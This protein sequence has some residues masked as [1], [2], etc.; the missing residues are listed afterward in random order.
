[1]G[2]W[3]KKAAEPSPAQGWPPKEADIAAIAEAH[4]GLLGAPAHRAISAGLRAGENLRALAPAVQRNGVI[5]WL[6]LTDIQMFVIWGVDGYDVFEDAD[7]VPNPRKIPF[8]VISALSKSPLGVASVLILKQLRSIDEPSLA[9]T[10]H[11]VR[12]LRDVLSERS[13]SADQEPLAEGAY[14]T[15]YEELA[16]ASFLWHDLWE[17][18]PPPL[19]GWYVDPL[20]G[21][22]ARRCSGGAWTSTAAPLVGPATTSRPHPRKK[23]TVQP[24]LSHCGR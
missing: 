1:M 9:V 6:G 22:L 10:D 23:A 2:F 11:F 14:T 18:F 8:G 21:C 24:D 7:S 5:S 20:N 12:V 4:G 13:A 16:E 17:S 19:A 3:K 15:P